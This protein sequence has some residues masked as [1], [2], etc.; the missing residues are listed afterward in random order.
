[1][2]EHNAAAVAELCRRLD[3][4]PLAIELAAR[5]VALPVEQLA[6][7]M[8]ERFRLLV[9]GS[10][11]AHPRHQSLRAAVDWSYDL[12][13]P[14]ERQL[15]ERIAIFED[16]FS[17]EAAEAIC[18]V[19]GTPSNAVLGCLRLLVEKSL[20]EIDVGSPGAR[21]RMLETLRQ[22]AMERLGMNAQAE[23]MRARHAGYYLALA[24]RA[25]Q[26]FLHR[27]QDVAWLDCLTRD[28]ANLQA[29]LRWF[30]DRG[31]AH[32]CLQLVMALGPPEQS[33]E[34]SG[35]QEQRVASILTPLPDQPDATPLPLAALAA[36]DFALNHSVLTARESQ[37]IELIARGLSNRDIAER[38][39]VSVRT[40]ERHITNL[41]AKIGVRGKAGATAYALRHGLVRS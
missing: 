13:A 6:A 4:L 19:D 1:L 37:V 33:A 3:G 34:S 22:Y 12:L 32:A 20:V 30:G 14:D 16:G 24:D 38:L 36:V 27:S 23:T 28:R 29:A 25:L 21:Y 39:V 15:F 17:L 2:S 35:W 40:V 10:R 5:M 18:G 8:D 7:R 41:Y 11:T 26:T 31:D 9:G